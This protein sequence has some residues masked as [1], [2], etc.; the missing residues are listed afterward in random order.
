MSIERMTIIVVVIIVTLVIVVVAA[1]GAAV[2]FGLALP[3]TAEPEAS[4]EYYPPNVLAYSWMTL[5][6]GNGQ[7]DHMLDM[8][9]RFEE[10]SGFEDAT[11]DVM[12]EFE[13]ETGIDFE[14]DVMT[15]IGFDMSAALIDLDI[16][17]ETVEFG[18]TIAVRDRQAANDFLN[19]W[20]AYMEESSEAD[21]DRDSESGFTIW[22]DESAYQVYALSDDLLVFATTRDT[23]D[24]MLERV[25]GDSDGALAT[26]E[27]FQQARAALPDRR[28]ASMYLDVE[29]AT[30][31]ATDSLGALTGFS[32]TDPLNVCPALSTEAPSWIAG[33][34]GWVERGVV[35]DLVS[36]SMGGG[37]QLDAPELADAAKLLPDDTLGFFSVSFDPVLDHYRENLRGCTLLE[38]MEGLSGG[39]DE[40]GDEMID[41]LGLGLDADSTLADVLDAG[42]DM[43][44]DQMGIDLESD[45]LD[46]LSGQFIV[47]VG[48][49][50]FQ[51][52][53]DAPEENSVDAV[54]MLSYRDGRE[55]ALGDSLDGLADELEWSLGVD[56]D[57]VDV[58]ADRDARMFPVEGTGYAP[59]YALHDGY[60]M[61]VTTEE[62]LEAVI[63]RQKGEGDNLSS[64]AEYGRAIGLLP[65]SGRARTYVALNRIVDGIDWLEAGLTRDEYELLGALGAVAASVGSDGGFDRFTL[66]LTLFP[67]E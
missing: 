57:R 34:A 46:H 27:D 65:E 45:L 33:S 43:V 17:D 15:W 22:E 58:G 31:A 62:A 14:A 60:L 12:N 19:D 1:V 44:E 52:V 4:A 41:D 63:A 6:P 39:T 54:V 48:D 29:E 40:F 13:S 49:F 59:G 21:F 67:E 53:M 30:A 42:L 64:Q 24:D 8:F 38:L 28:F 36:P 16:D 3:S 47:S 37:W 9:R 2:Y 32:V 11:D 7:R 66:A 55:E 25:A 5:N 10:M 51:A 61:F 23:L 18:A 50:D 20:L 56:L 26:D 35:F